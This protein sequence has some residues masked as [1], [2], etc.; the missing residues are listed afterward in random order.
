MK[1][2]FISSE[3]GIGRAAFTIRIIV[4]VLVA[5]GIS[6]AALAYFSHWEEGTFRPLGIYLGILASLFCS[7]IALMQVLKR[8]RDMGKQ[9]YYSLLLLIPGVNVLFL[10]Y[11]MAAPSKA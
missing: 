1:D 6:Y 7:L 10:L 2:K 4:L 9:P 5:G 11:A 3:G 8:L